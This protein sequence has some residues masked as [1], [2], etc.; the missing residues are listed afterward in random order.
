MHTRRLRRLAGLRHGC[1]TPGASTMGT[2][3]RTH[4]CTNARAQIRY[5]PF[6]FSFLDFMSDGDAPAPPFPHAPSAQRR[7]CTPTHAHP[8]PPV[9]PFTPLVVRTS[10]DDLLVVPSTTKAHATG[11]QACRHVLT[12][13]THAPRSM[14]PRR[15][16]CA[17]CDLS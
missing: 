7:W 3:V 10:R 9:F 13:H 11:M 17:T 14:H 2:H 8:R 5:V 15:P 6:C 4:T 16:P 12:P 1:V